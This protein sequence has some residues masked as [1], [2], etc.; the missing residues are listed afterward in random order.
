MSKQLNQRSILTSKGSY[1]VVE[2]LSIENNLC[3]G[4][5]FISNS[6]KKGFE[7]IDP[8]IESFVYYLFKDKEDICYQG[9]NLHAVLYYNVLFFEETKQIPVN[10]N[11]FEGNELK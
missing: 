3:K 6:S 2:P 8:S 7:M 5:V 4:R 10:F 9:K 1:L 11:A